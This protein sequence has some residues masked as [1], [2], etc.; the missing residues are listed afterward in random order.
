MSGLTTEDPIITPW[1]LL[2]YWREA[3]A[4]R[5]FVY[6]VTAYDV[7]DYPVKI[8]YAAD[9]EQRLAELQCGNPTTLGLEVILLGTRRT[10]AVLHSHWR[11]Y[12]RVRGEWFGRG[13]EAAIINAGLEMAERQVE[14]YRAG[15][16]IDKL[17]TDVI[18]QVLLELDGVAA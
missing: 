12:A 4:S 8:G 18:S 16:K 7:D 10:E 3:F 13:Y 15:C 14:A 6:F 11:D 1:D 5:N 2:P 9:P 17:H